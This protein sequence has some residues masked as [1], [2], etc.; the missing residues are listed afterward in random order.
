MDD[1][2]PKQLQPSRFVKL[3]QVD[4]MYKNQITSVTMDPDDMVGLPELINRFINYAASKLSLYYDKKDNRNLFFL[5]WRHQDYDI[6][7]Y[8]RD[9]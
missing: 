7:R 3:S 6:R 1:Q 5:G 9:R 8:F 4:E 2:K